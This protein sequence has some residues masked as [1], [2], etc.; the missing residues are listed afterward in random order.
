MRL[1]HGSAVSEMDSNFKWEL[2]LSPYE[3]FYR[4]YRELRYGSCS[5]PLLRWTPELFIRSVYMTVM[6]H[7][8]RA[9]EYGVLTLLTALKSHSVAVKANI[10]TAEDMDKIWGHPDMLLYQFQKARDP[11]AIKP[12]TKEA[13]ELED[14]MKELQKWFESGE[15][16]RVSGV[17]GR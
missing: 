14:T 10:K 15:G 6:D 8:R 9:E 17:P 12:F 5:L 4:N 13:D 11:S 2:P 3:R 1:K 7:E 16:V